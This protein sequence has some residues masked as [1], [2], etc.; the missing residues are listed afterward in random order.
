M[1]AIVAEVSNTPWIEMYP[2]V[3]H[4]ASTDKVE[5]LRKNDDGQTNYQF[6]KTFH[7]SPFMEMSYMYDWI[8]EGEEAHI[9]SK[10]DGSLRVTTAM[11]KEEDGS[12]RFTA[13][14]R[15]KQAGLH[16]MKLAWQLARYPS[17][18][19]IIQIWIHYEAF[20]LFWKGVSYQPH[21]NGSETTA[22]RMIGTL[23][24]PFFQLQAWLSKTETKEI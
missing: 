13:T 23:M 1:D 2:Y 24:A 21:P 9:I 8:F 14:M 12:K 4:P 16:P 20:W 10:N 22:S 7:V 11:V 17:Y 3:L 19:A 6:P 5:C 18:C 15:V